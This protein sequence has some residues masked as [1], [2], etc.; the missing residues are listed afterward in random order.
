V[1]EGNCEG[2]LNR[3][4]AILEIIRYDAHIR[5]LLTWKKGGQMNDMLD[6]S[7]WPPAGGNHQDV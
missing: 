4:D 6:L 7:F 3:E 1:A 5:Q 2:R